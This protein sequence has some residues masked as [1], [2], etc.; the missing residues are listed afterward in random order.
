MIEHIPFGRTGHNSS[1]MIFGAAALG[2]MSQQRASGVL[3]MLP[4]HGV[5]H[6]DTAASYGD[7]ELRLAPW[8]AS[9]RDEVFL[10]TKT[11]DRT[12]D[13]ARASL[14]NSLTRLGV[15]RVDLIQMHNLVDEAEWQTAMGPDG[16]LEALIEARDQGLVRFIGVTGHGTRVAAMHL[17]SLEQFDFDSVLLPY[18]FA[19]MQQPEYADDFEALIALCLQRD[20]AVQTIKSIARRRWTE[21]DEDKRFS[22]YMPIREPEALRRAVHYVLGRP[23]LFLNTSS[24]ATILAETLTIAAESASAPDDAELTRDVTTMGIEP[25]FVRGVSDTV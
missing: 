8:L 14:R 23:G 3:D 24:D 20:V 22:W 1:R 15:E 25:L 6:I 11:G 2:A 7:S 16:A 12:A 19:M 9:H 13:G 10:A 4:G 21:Q 5:N 17:R 18:N